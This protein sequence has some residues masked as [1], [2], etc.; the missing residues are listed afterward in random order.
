MQPG[1]ATKLC[2]RTAVA[3]AVLAAACSTASYEPGKLTP[4]QV[5]QCRAV[6]AAYRAQAAD[7]PAKR[8]AMKQDPVAAGWLT[9][10]FV[11]DVFTVREGR[12]LGGDEELFRAAIK[13]E[14]PTEVRALAEIKELGA[15]AVPTLVGDLLL[16]EQ[17]HPRELGVELLAHVGAPARPELLRIVREGET[18]QQR[19]AMRSL[20]M[21]GVDAEVMAM[22]RVQ[23]NDEDFTV[24]ADALRCLRHAGPE[25]QVLL[26]E[27]M[28]QDSDPF[29]RRVAAETLAHFRSSK[30]ALVLVDY[31]ERCKRDK[32]WPGEL[33]AQ[34]ALQRMAGKRGPRTPEAWR[35]AAPTFDQPR[36][37]PA[38]SDPPR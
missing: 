8:D 23:A 21:C 11:R 9:R 16:H 29:V 15:M 38:S 32:D 2:R 3:V 36:P 24:R 25:G 13:A 10:M 22:L 14:D 30:T 5:A 17:P 34:K 28:Q 37:V 33:A 26:G 4:D 12:P 6:E 20:A 7:Y 35:A 19:A 31:L 18:R 27:R 1:A